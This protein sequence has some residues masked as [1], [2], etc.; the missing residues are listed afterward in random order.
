MVELAAELAEAK[1]LRGLDTIHLAS[2]LLIHRRTRE[3]V[4]FMAWDRALLRAASDMGLD[5]A[6]P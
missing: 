1:S 2:S 3:T 5:I 6:V 4:R